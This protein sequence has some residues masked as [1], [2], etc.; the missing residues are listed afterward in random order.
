MVSSR[1]HP[2]KLADLAFSFLNLLLPA[3]NAL[4]E[5]LA[6]LTVQFANTIIQFVRINHV[7]PAMV[8]GIIT[9]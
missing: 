3:S 2:F 7:E 9:E 8:Y 4:I 6:T 5:L 1:G